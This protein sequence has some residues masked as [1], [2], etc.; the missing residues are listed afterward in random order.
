MEVERLQIHQNLELRLRYMEQQD[1]LV[2]LVQPDLQERVEPPVL[3]VHQVHPEPPG[4]AEPPERAER[5]V[6]LEL[7]EQV[8]LQDPQEH[9]EQ[10]E[11]RVLL[12][13]PEQ[14]VL[15]EPPEQVVLQDPP[16]HLEQAGHRVLVV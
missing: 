11:R 6:L 4:L 12:E 3:L 13:L 1:P 5:R 14:V 2:L 15:R 7:L 10:A 16:E 8:V 9:P